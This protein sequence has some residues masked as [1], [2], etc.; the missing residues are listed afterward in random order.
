MAQPITW[1]NITAPSFGEA[2]RLMGLAQQSILGA[3]DNGKAAL[4]DTDKF[5][6]EL[7]KRQ[8]Q[9]A[10]QDALGKIYQAQNLDQFNALNQS[11]AL[12]QAVAAN[13]ARIDRAQINALRDGRVGTLQQREKQAWE[14]ANAALDQ[15]EAP[16]VDQVKGLLAQGDLAGAKPLI[17]GLSARGQATML[18]ALDQ[19]ER[20]MIERAR[21]DTEFGWKGAEETFK[22]QKRP[23]ELK[24]EQGKVDSIP[25]QQEQLK[26]Q[27]NASKASVA[28]SNENVLASRARRERDEAEAEKARE[29]KKLGVALDGNIYKEG[30]YKDADS[31]AIAELM[32]T[33]GAGGDGPGDNDQRR[34]VLERLNKLAQTGVE[35]TQAGPDGKPVKTVVPLP[36]G[37]VKAALLSSE[38]QF[39]SW[40]GGYAESF[41][42]NLKKRLQAVYNKPGADGKP[43]AANKAADDYQNFLAIMR[44]TAE[45]APAP[46]SKR[47]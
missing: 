17:A 10:T 37:A 1:Q 33:T 36:L 31:V 23:L 20:L 38:D 12:D 21:G 7:W 6:Q 34:K 3:F 9:D 40:N 47:K 32:K 25:L 14:F 15:K 44:G 19:R 43:M 8:D 27:T 5:N 13:G 41:E 18:G 26:A 35:L 22:Q 28:A 42:D 2:N 45:A 24:I 46:S 30:V 4:A 11:G 29:V 16:V 39:L